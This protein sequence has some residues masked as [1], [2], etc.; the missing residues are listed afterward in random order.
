MCRKVTRSGSPRL[1]TVSQNLPKP[2]DPVVL[3]IERQGKLLYISFET[4]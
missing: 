1:T 4:E 3:Q 2:S